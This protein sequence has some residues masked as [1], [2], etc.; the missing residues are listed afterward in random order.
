MWIV[1]RKGREIRGIGPMQNTRCG[2]RES[3]SP[4]LG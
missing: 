2:V 4:G 1:L 3:Y